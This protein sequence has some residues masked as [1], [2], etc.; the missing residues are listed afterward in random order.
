[1]AQ[2]GS[3]RHETDIKLGQ[4]VFLILGGLFK[5]VIIANY[6]AS[7]F[8]DGVFRDPSAQTSLDLIL[9]MYGYA[10]EIYCDFSAYTDI[11][12][13]IA[14]LLG[15]EF[16]QNFNYPYRATSVQD[17]WRRWHMS[18]SSWLRDYLY[19]PLGGSKDGTAATYRNIM[20][21]MGLGGLWHGASWNFLIWGILHGSALVVER[22][23]GWAGSTKILEPTPLRR[24][25]GWLGTALGWFLTFQFVCVTWVFF[26]AT[27]TETWLSYF[28]TMLGGGNWT[29]T[30]TPFIV[31]IFALGALSHLIPPVCFRVLERGYEAAP[32]VI[33]VL[34]PFIVIFLISVAAPTGVAPF[35]YFQF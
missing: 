6:L 5:K 33:K 26:R 16:P 17:F 23:L 8:V 1:L 32:L 15:Y 21:T 13:G 29:T 9:G 30:V 28:S 14:N 2:T 35:I 3:E 34:V 27:S 11:A 20:I 12:I 24:A 10:L 4:S 19:I 7:E 18:L 31:V 25:L 22:M